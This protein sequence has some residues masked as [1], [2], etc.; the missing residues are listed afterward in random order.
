MV[1]EL[2]A[3]PRTT[4]STKGAVWLP[5][6]VLLK[7][8]GFARLS[9]RRSPAVLAPLRVL[10]VLALARRVSS[11]RALA[12]AA[13]YAGPSPLLD[14]YPLTAAI[15]SAISDSCSARFAAWS[16]RG[17]SVEASCK[18]R[19]LSALSPSAFSFSCIS[20]ASSTSRISRRRHLN[21]QRVTYS[22]VFTGINTQLQLYMS[23][24][25]RGSLGR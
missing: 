23:L 19:V 4:A 21:P 17:I 25:L 12:A 16:R 6:E 7:V 15:F 5:H 8:A 24:V 13:K 20:S 1:S 14:E 2:R 11:R 18:A 3:S 22:S 10:P 9:R